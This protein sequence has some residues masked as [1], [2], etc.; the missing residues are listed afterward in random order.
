M[1][2]LGAG[3]IILVLVL[4][5]FFFGARRLPE[6]ARGL[7]EGIRN[8]KGALRSSDEESDEK[9]RLEPGDDIEEE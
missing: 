6:F 8:F 5:V 4:I 7:G 1:F 9:P 2:G 3:E